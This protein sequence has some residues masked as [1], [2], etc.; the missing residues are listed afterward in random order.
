MP[1]LIASIFLANHDY[2]PIAQFFSFEGQ[3]GNQF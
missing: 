1:I 3:N 2:D